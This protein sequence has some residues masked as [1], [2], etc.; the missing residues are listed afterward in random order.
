[1]TNVSVSGGDDIK[2]SDVSAR[3]SGN[4][5]Y[6]TVSEQ[7]NE[8]PETVTITVDTDLPDEPGSFTCDSAYFTSE[9]DSQGMLY[10]GKGRWYTGQNI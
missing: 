6:V 10:A 8:M 2:T 7:A 5:L 1:M 9:V 3:I 4:N